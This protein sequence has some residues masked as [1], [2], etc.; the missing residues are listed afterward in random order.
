M[1]DGFLTT[2]SF[3]FNHS[4]PQSKSVNILPYKNRLIDT[5]LWNKTFCEPFEQSV[6]SSTSS[7]ISSLT[8]DH[9]DLDE[10][11]SLSNSSKLNC[12]HLSKK[13]SQKQLS[14]PQTHVLEPKQSL[15]KNFFKLNKFYRSQER[16]STTL[17]LQTNSHKYFYDECNDNSQIVVYERVWNLEEQQQQFRKKLNDLSNNTISSLSSLKSLSVDS[18]DTFQYSDCPYVTTNDIINHQSTVH[19]LNRID[20]HE[21]LMRAP[22]FQEGL[23]RDICEEYLY[24]FEPGAFVIRKSYTHNK[25]Y[26]LSLRVPR[27]EKTFVEHYLIENIDNGYRIKLLKKYTSPHEPRNFSRGSF[28]SDELSMTAIFLIIFLSTK[29]ITVVADE[30]AINGSENSIPSAKELSNSTK[31][32]QLQITADTSLSANNQSV[33]LSTP[34]QNETTTGS[35]TTSSSKDES[36]SS[37]SSLPQTITINLSEN[38]ATNPASQN[39]SDAHATITDNVAIEASSANSNNSNF[40]TEFSSVITSN[41]KNASE[42]ISTSVTVN[43]LQKGDNSS[44][45]LTSTSID[46]THPKIAF[47]KNDSSLSLNVTLTEQN[48]TMT[49]KNY[50]SIHKH[51]MVTPVGHTQLNISSE[52]Q[53]TNNNMSVEFGVSEKANQN[54]TQSTSNTTVDD[55]SEKLKLI[56][57]K[58]VV[59]SNNTEHLFN[60]TMEKLYHLVE[61]HLSNFSTDLPS[62]SSNVVARIVHT[63]EDDHGLTLATTSQLKKG[64]VQMVVDTVKD[65]LYDILAQGP[66]IVLNTTIRK[67]FGKENEH[68]HDNIFISFQKRNES[69]HRHSEN[70]TKF[71]Q[72]QLLTARNNTASVHVDTEDSGKKVLKLVDNSEINI[73]KFIEIENSTTSSESTCS[74]IV[75]I[76]E[77]SYCAKLEIKVSSSQS[78]NQTGTAR[79][80]TEIVTLVKILRPAIHTLN[81]AV[82]SP[83]SGNIEHSTHGSGSSIKSQHL[84]STA[85]SEV[86]ASWLQWL[87]STYPESKQSMVS[88]IRTSQADQSDQVNIIC[89]YTNWSQ[90]RNGA[91]KFYPENIDPTLCTHIIYAFGQIKDGVIA[92]Y[93]WN[94]EDSEWST[95]MMSRMMALKKQN[96]SLK[97]LLGVGGWNHG[98]GKFSDMVQNT[99]SRNTFVRTAVI[100]LQMHKFDGLD[101]DWEYPGSRD[102]S[103]PTDKVFYTTLLQELKRAFQ[104]Y[105]LLLSAALAAG[106]STI[107]AGYE[108]SNVCNLLDLVNIMAYDLHGSWETKTG[109]NSPLF[110]RSSETGA[111]KILNTDWVI[112]Y[113][114]SNGCSPSKINMG[115]ALYGRTFRLS[116]PSQHDI[117]APANGAGAAGQFTGEAGFLSYYE[118]CQKLQQGWTSVYDEESKG[119]YAYKNSDW[120]GY[121]DMYT[122]AYKAQYA[123]KMGLKGLMFWALDLDDFS[124][125]FCNQ[126]KYPLINTAIKSIRGNSLSLPSRPPLPVPSTTTSTPASF[127]IPSGTNTP[128]KPSRIVCYYTNWA[129]YRPGIGKFVP[130]NLDVSLCT[131][132]IFAFAVLKNSQLAS[133][134][135]NDE[136]TEWSKGMYSRLIALKTNNPSLKVSLAVGGWNFGSG[137]FSNMVSDTSLRQAFVT[138][139]SQFIR[140]HNFDGLDIDWEY[141]GSRDGSRPGDKALFITLLKELKREFSQYNLLLTAAVGAGQST[142]LAAYEIE[143]MA[144]YLD[145]IN[146]MTYDLHGGSWEFTTGLHT[147]LYARPEETGYAATLNA[148]WAVRYW[149]ANGMPKEKIVMGLATYGRTFKLNSTQTSIGAS[150]SGPGDAGKYTGEAGFLSYYEICEKLNNGWTK[151]YD[152]VQKSMYAYGDQNWVGYDDV[153]TIKIRANYIMAMGLSGAM[154]WAPDL[155]DFSGTFC[156]KGKYPLM[157]IVIDTF[158]SSVTP[159]VVQPITIATPGIDIDT[160]LPTIAPASS[161]PVDSVDTN[162]NQPASARNG[163]LL[164]LKRLKNTNP[165]LKIV[166]ALGKWTP[167]F[168]NLIRNPQQRQSFNEEATEFLLTYQF[169]G[170]DIDWRIPSESINL[171][172][173]NDKNLLNIWLKEL[174]ESFDR[175]EWL[176]TVSVSPDKALI[177]GAYEAFEMSKYVN[178]INLM[179]FGFTSSARSI[180]SLISPLY[181]TADQIGSNRY[182]N[183]HWTVQYWIMNGMPSDKISLGLPLFGKS[184]TLSNPTLTQIGSMTTGPGKSGQN[185]NKRGLLS[186]D[187]ICQKLRTQNWK[188]S[189]SPQ[190]RSPFAYSND[191]QWVS[192]E[193]MNSLRLKTE[194]SKLQNLAGVSL[195]SLDMDDYT[196][197]YCKQGKYPL[198]RQVYDTLMGNTVKTIKK[199][200]QIPKKELTT[201]ANVFCAITSAS[202]ENYGPG[203]FSPADVNAHLCTH[204]VIESVQLDQNLLVPNDQEFYTKIVQL[205][206]TNPFLKLIVSMSDDYQMITDLELFVSSATNYVQKYG[207]DGLIIKWSNFADNQ[208]IIKALRKSFVDQNL[209]L[210]MSVATSISKESAAS[211]FTQVLSLQAYIDYLI[212]LPVDYSDVMNATVAEA[213]NGITSL[214]SSD[215]SDTSMTMESMV[216]LLLSSGLSREKLI[217]SI[218]TYGISYKLADSSKFNF[219]DRV[220]S[221]GEPGQYTHTCSSFNS[222]YL[223]GTVALKARYIR[224]NKLS[225]ALIYPMD[226]DD[227]SGQF[228]Q[229][230]KYPI[231]STVFNILSEVTHPTE[232]VQTTAT[233]T[234]TT[235]PGINLCSGKE[236][237]IPDILD[238]RFYYVCLTKSSKPVAH[239]QCPSNMFFSPAA[240]ACIESDFP[241]PRPHPAGVGDRSQGIPADP[242]SCELLK[243]A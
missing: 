203:K 21:L 115:M 67:S 49:E 206:Q 7:G 147:A 122:I 65:I 20:D 232:N 149:M 172:R 43:Q 138:Q 93:E 95:G 131:N 128:T 22:W 166:L 66:A 32:T 160:T 48:N 92:A 242:Y 146:L 243:Q 218:P 187:E 184:F 173:S 75:K 235:Q 140:Q 169:D 176:L 237:L 151:V 191:G 77:Q 89:Y 124:G 120:V 240:K 78:Q 175:L 221:A 165:A 68:M 194:Y 144:K 8:S 97:V 69:V 234:T 31:I 214:S 181:A 198:V 59:I 34:V 52:I 185:L 222:H 204:L 121:D 23:S 231:T 223:N 143:N 164:Q 62:S 228:C 195:V 116:S 41:A 9:E 82:F 156:N 70:T 47:T 88:N 106:K 83:P 209:L 60:Q 71:N 167:D 100:Y 239:L 148:D 199:P 153:D 197:D 46:L 212:V 6:N 26:A 133:Y 76:A 238:C 5:S 141:P 2:H 135:W 219:G 105:G 220:I 186:Y 118:I 229:Q 107:D 182:Q 80:P 63:I 225:G 134:E 114:I 72:G 30:Q 202:Q 193:D 241:R 94:D 99:T 37:K 39:R 137:E 179:S 171:L 224:E 45:K 161:E 126:G 200:N 17:S 38:N 11:S 14:C 81:H 145:F 73:F 108:I 25:S 28:T 24:L 54:S 13:I 87:T 79:D 117:G 61:S 210:M 111:D 127:S 168:L 213:W 98:S 178:F 56:E 189:Y 129:Q 4:P 91:G 136:D 170:L 18:D 192:Y 217:L 211:I 227:F 188:R 174:R 130:D 150:S 230:G 216:K 104:P 159:V 64:E 36:E 226:L 3:R 119:N 33:L 205:K 42:S 109:I 86:P 155:D 74:I 102:G 158:K 57:S 12:F 16:I 1:M 154:F 163:I 162:P 29:V 201:S 103:R 183:I 85:S 55:T 180:V 196:G 123:Q 84:T 50:N 15:T 208:I 51:E 190:T 101:L 233:T 44:G 152:S 27:T 177:D 125:S 90:Y 10:I 58:T 207:F 113:W 215:R 53:G 132:I 142:I 157:N 96:P 236:D 35:N 110:G 19:N 139:A 112:Q 40:H